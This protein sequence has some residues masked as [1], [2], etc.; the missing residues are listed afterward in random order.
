LEK[1]DSTDTNKDTPA[2]YVVAPIKEGIYLANLESLK[3][4]IDLLGALKKIKERP[5]PIENEVMVKGLKNPQCLIILGF[6][7]S[8]VL[9]AVRRLKNKEV[10]YICVIEPDLAVFYQTIRRHYVAQFLTDPSIDFII[11]VPMAELRTELYKAFSRFETV[12]GPR[13]SVAQQPEIIPDPFYFAKDGPGNEALKKELTQCVVDASKQV[14]ISMGC[15]PDSFNRWL[16]SAKNFDNLQ[17]KYSMKNLKG[18]F[19]NVPAVVVGAGPSMEEFI[20]YAKEYDLEN[21]A[22]I[23]AC[24]ASLRRL[25]KEGIRPHFVTRCERKLTGIFDGV[26]RDET[27]DIFYVAYPWT[28]REFFNLFDE[29]FIV[30][31]GNGVCNWTGY[32]HLQVNGGVSSANAALELAWELGCK[33]V[34]LTGI[35]LCFVGDKSHVGG[36]KVEF[37]INKSKEFW[38]KIKN[39]KGEEVTTIPVWN[40]CLNEYVTSIMKYNIKRPIN[41]YNTSVEGAVIHGASYNQWGNISHIFEKTHKI[42]KLI[43]NNVKRQTDKDLEKFGEIKKESI[44]ELTQMKTDLKEVFSTIDDYMQNNMREEHKIVDQSKGLYDPTEFFRA[45]EQYKLAL[46]SIY[47]HPCKAI[48]GF[49][50][51]W[52][53]RESFSNLILDTVQLDLFKAENRANAL[54]NTMPIEYERLKYYT[55]IHATLFRLLDYYVGEMIRLINGEDMVLKEVGNES[56]I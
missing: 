13:A 26:T 49:K 35:D 32:D 56:K 15:S 7:T 33:D 22:L 25:L 36:T 23:I 9:E 5:V 3:A 50:N 45:V 14:F 2:K 27:K 30:Y 37:D 20:K 4:N 17:E 24:D 21:K 31:R 54:K 12:T 6:T 42:V 16:Q 29:S 10:R 55:T 1:Q 46:K 43:R 18:K 8:K 47:S 28:D 11:G 41:I 34:V 51:K 19:A 48:D 53:L 38:T 39:N 52:Y 40:R 44:K